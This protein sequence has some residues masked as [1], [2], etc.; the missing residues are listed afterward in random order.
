MVNINI[1]LFLTLGYSNIQRGVW[2]Q[3][4]NPL[5]PGDGKRYIIKSRRNGDELISARTMFPYNSK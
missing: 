4:C 3:D 5:E 1:I 2:F